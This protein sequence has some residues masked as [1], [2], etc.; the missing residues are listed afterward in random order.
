MDARSQWDLPVMLALIVWLCTFPIV[1][2]VG[3]PL[4]GWKL[5]LTA[6]FG[7]LLGILLVCWV[8]C[9]GAI[10]WGYKKKTHWSDSG[11]IPAGGTRTE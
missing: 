1:V 11:E 9:F 7:L 2:A 4:L 8:L 6:A 10:W 3:V 5:A